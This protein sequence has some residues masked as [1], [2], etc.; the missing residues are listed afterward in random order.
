[1]VLLVSYK[2]YRFK[3]SMSLQNCTDLLLTPLLI[4]V[5]IWALLMAWPISSKGT[6]KLTY[7]CIVQSIETA[8]TDRSYRVL[9]VYVANAMADIEGTRESLSQKKK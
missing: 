9:K 1:M 4:C 6:T 5:I 3:K 2:V 8:T 7:Q